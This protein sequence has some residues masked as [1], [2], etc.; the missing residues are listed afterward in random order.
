MNR[1]QKKC[2][3]MSAGFH[4]LLVVIL[5]I[6]PAFFTSKSKTEDVQTIL[7]LPSKLIDDNKMGGGNPNVKPPPAAAAVVTPPLAKPA[8][9]PEQKAERVREPD[10]PKDVV[11]PT[12][13]LEPS[14]EHKRL[15]QVSTKPV[16]RTTNPKVTAK[17][18]P[19]IDPRIQQIAAARKQLARDI[20]RTAEDIHESASPS[21]K[22]EDPD[23]GPGG[24][25]PSYANYAA[26]VRTVYENA[27]V[28]PEDS[29]TDHGVTKVSVTIRRDGTIVSAQIIKQSG[30]AQMDASVRRALDRVT[31][32][33]RPFPEGDNGKER[34]YIIP[35]DLKVKRGQ[36]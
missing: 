13:S 11:K 4:L 29:A 10:P 23:L 26:W 35:F 16:S 18:A 21:T 9:P 28:V 32:I 12:E 7:F 15:P 1:F 6:G 17:Q 5:L 22:I 20:R 8:P 33:G 24:G 31:T 36:A 14:H 19:E 30:D 27:W 3:I 2:F 25:G 34:T